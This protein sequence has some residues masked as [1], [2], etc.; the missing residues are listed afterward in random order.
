M[1]KAMVDKDEV[2]ALDKPA[3]DGYVFILIR[4]R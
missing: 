3:V 4:I 1:T 2:K